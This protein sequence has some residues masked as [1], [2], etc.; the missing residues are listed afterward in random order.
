MGA[1]SNFRQPAAGGST[2]LVE[3]MGKVSLELLPA[4]A[5]TA[6][7]WAGALACLA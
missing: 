7:H 3:G 2:L 5:P 6:A 1:M 4:S